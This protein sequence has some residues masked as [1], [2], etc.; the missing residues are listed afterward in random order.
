MVQ[1]II[2]FIVGVR[3]RYPSLRFLAFNPRLGV[4]PLEE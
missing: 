3:E 2:A 4:S 1:P